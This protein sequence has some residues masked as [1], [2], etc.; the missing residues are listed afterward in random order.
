[1]DFDPG[2]GG[3]GVRAQLKSDKQ[4]TGPG[5]QMRED[6]KKEQQENQTKES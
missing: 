1:M 2:R 3:Y 6:L 4:L 5:V